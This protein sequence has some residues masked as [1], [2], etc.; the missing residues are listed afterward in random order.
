[1]LQLYIYRYSG[2]DD[3]K[4]TANK[5]GSTRDVMGTWE[6][7]IGGY[8][9]DT[10]AEYYGQHNQVWCILEECWI[11]SNKDEQDVLEVYFW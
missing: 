3:C 9:I 2:D 5:G 8:I 10:Y 4:L 7:Y 11:F 6:T 1:M